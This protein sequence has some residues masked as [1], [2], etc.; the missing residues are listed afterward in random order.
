MT[1]AGAVPVAAGNWNN[2]LISRGVTKQPAVEVAIVRK[3][4]PLRP[5]VGDAPMI[6]NFTVAG[7]LPDLSGFAIGFVSQGHALTSD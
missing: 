4:R 7:E 3:C 6:D 2:L 1:A 5:E